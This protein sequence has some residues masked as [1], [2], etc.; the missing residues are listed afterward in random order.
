MNNKKKLDMDTTK[1]KL[2]ANFLDNIDVN[3]LNEIL[4]H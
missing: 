4:A 3:I 2:Y 1:R